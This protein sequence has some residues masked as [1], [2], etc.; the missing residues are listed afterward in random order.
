MQC[1]SVVLIYSLLE[2]GCGLERV[3]GH[4]NSVDICVVVNQELHNLCLPVSRCV[5]KRSFVVIVYSP[6]KN[7]CGPKI[8][9]G[10]NQWR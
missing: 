2:D 4:T 10:T 1:S 7:D 5:M 8:S 9:C 6:V 3:Q